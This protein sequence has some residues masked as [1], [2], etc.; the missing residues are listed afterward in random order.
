[1]KKKFFF[2]MDPPNEPT[3][4]QTNQQDERKLNEQI[5]T[6]IH[7][8]LLFSGIFIGYSKVIEKWLIALRLAYACLII[9]AC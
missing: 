3:N 7:R 6:Y 1:M 9:G 8:L 5:R 4:Q 2:R